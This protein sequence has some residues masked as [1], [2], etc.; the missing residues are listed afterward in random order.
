MSDSINATP[1]TTASVNINEL[2]RE[3]WQQRL[4]DINELLVKP[5]LVAIVAKR[6]AE[7][8]RFV[9]LAM[10]EA[11][12]IERIRNQK[13]FES[14]LMN[15]AEEY[16]SL[17]LVEAQRRRARRPRG[18]V[19]VDG[20]T[21]NQIVEMLVSKSE[22]RTLTAPE[23]WPHFFAELDKLDLDPKE[24][25]AA[26]QKKSEYSYEFNGKKRSITYGRFANLVSK[27]RQKSR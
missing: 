17:A 16:G 4:A 11:V 19:T 13:S 2:H 26:N 20:R 1:M 25:K 8:A 27:Y 24:I 9:K 21:L 12:R 3:F 23:L 14:E 22:H 6:E 7:K 10:T 15:V 5:H 18:K